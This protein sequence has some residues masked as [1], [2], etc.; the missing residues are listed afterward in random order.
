MKVG[1][2]LFEQL[3]L[4]PNRIVE[5]Q[6]DFSAAAIHFQLC[7]KEINIIF[8]FSRKK[9]KSSQSCTLA[10]TDSAARSWA[11]ASCSLA[12]CNATS[13]D[14]FRTLSS[15]SWVCT[16]R[17]KP[18][19]SLKSSISPLSEFSSVSFVCCSVIS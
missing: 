14:A 5:N 11:S 7:S 1:R 8:I 3:H 2:N 4:F 12:C 13:S 19:C 17:I 6:L 16:L 15:S 18:N 10:R 9:S